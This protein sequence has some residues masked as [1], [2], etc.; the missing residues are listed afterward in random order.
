[1]ATVKGGAR[2]KAARSALLAYLGV[3]DDVPNWVSGKVCLAHLCDHDSTNGWCMNPQHLYVGTY[4]E[5]SLDR[6]P[7][8]TDGYTF[9][10]SRVRT[11]DTVVS[12]KV[13]EHMARQLDRLVALKQVE[14]TSE[15]LRR[16]KKFTQ[17]DALN[18]ALAL[19]L[20]E[21]LK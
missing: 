15:P 20:K 19:Y 13:S 14:Q 21:E 5:N 2:T 16:K 4:S 7:G 18:I 9:Y 17:S 6:R 3:E 10:L 11:R 1:M 12:A 8:K